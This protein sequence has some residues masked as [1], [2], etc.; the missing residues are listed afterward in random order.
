MS[1]LLPYE[2]I[3][4]TLGAGAW[5][6]PGARVVGD[7]E[8]GPDANVWYNA[9]LRG[10]VQSIRVGARTNIQDLVMLH[11]VSNRFGCILGDDV[12]VGHS[13]VLHGCTIERGCLIGMGA[14]VLDG[15]HV[16]EFCLIGAG[17]LVAP[18]K[19]IPPR[20]VVMGSP[21]K[22][23][24][25]VTDDEVASFL[26]SAVHYVQLAQRHQKSISG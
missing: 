11:V 21:G 15:A 24:R 1:E 12:T 4:P 23:V 14:I 10:D 5:V 13:A 26:H 7:V 25:Q 2:G 17:A 6:A 19:V 9:V 18:G 20:S 8:L 3:F 16:G 22:I